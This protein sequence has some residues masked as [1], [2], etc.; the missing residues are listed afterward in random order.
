MHGL[1]NRAFQGFVTS[2]FGEDL[3]DEVRDQADLPIDD[4]ESMTYYDDA[5]TVAVFNTTTQLLHRPSASLLED[6]GTFL[7]THPPLDP[8]R[9]LLRFGGSTFPEFIWSL[10]ELRDRG[11]LVM[12]DLDIPKIAVAQLDKRTFRLSAQWQ[13]PGISAIL[14]G[15]LRAM[16]DDYGTLAILSLDGREEADG[17]GTEFLKVEL[18][19]VQH[20]EGRSFQLGEVLA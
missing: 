11:R 16:A 5:L 3:W 13:L 1:I 15:G 18:L 6:M 10:E 14:L 8:L 20:A 17:I 2:T 4:F 7:V 19:D 12:P 9:R